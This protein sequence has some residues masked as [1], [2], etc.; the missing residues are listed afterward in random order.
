MNKFWII[1]GIIV[2]ITIIGVAIFWLNQSEAKI[3]TLIISSSGKTDES[4]AIYTNEK[5]ALAPESRASITLKNGNVLRLEAGTEIEIINLSNIILKRGKVWSEVNK[6]EEGGY[7]VET[8]TI[9]ATVRGTIFSVLYEN[10]I[11]EVF[12]EKGIVLV[13]LNSDPSIFKE[14]KEGELFTDFEKPAPTSTPKII[15]QKQ[16]P[17]KTAPIKSLVKIEISADRSIARQNELVKL[18][19][20]GIYSDGEVVNLSGKVSWIQNPTLGIIDSQNNLHLSFTG[21]AKITAKFE[22]LISN[23]ISLKVEEQLKQE[24]PPPPPQEPTSNGKNR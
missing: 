18:E 5:I 15:K 3:G 24:P 14:V 11:N 1:G 6:L 7:K 10:L 12:V 21:D 17:I 8:P 22:N 4:R 13:T 20:K 19:A 23:I 9:T 2:L 16:E